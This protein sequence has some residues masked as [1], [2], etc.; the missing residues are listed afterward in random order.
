MSFPLPEVTPL[1]KPYWDGLQSGRLRFQRCSA[2][3]HAWLPARADC[4]ECWTAQ[5]QWTDASGR[6]RVVSWV[7]YHHAYHPEFKDRV[8]YNVTLVELDE[9]PRLITNVVNLGN[10]KLA[11]EMPVKLCIESEH[12]VALARFELE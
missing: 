2:C 3:G 5:W 10:R 6:G 8:P 12:G 4:P 1:S 11:I 9:G 7:V